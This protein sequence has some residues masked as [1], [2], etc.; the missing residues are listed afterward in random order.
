MVR[1][2]PL[3]LLVGKLVGFISLHLFSQFP[4]ETCRSSQRTHPFSFTILSLQQP[5][6]A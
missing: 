4:F 6:T 1:I 3:E 2:A 5:G